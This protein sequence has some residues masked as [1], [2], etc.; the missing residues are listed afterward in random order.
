AKFAIAKQPIFNKE[1]QAQHTGERKARIGEDAEGDVEGEHRTVSRWRGQTI[2]RSKVRGKKK[3]KDE[4]KD[5]SANGTL[6]MVELQHKR[7]ERQQ[8]AEQ[9]HR[10]GK[11][12]IG[13]GVEALGALQQ[14]EIVRDQP[15]GKQRRADSAR[16]SFPGVQETQVGDKAQTVGKN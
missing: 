8:P 7:G 2:A 12:V 4:R 3:N 15:Y 9:G 16:C 10:T 14:G 11:V 13:D 6:A 5:E 1:N